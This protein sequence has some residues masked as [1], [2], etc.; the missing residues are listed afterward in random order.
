MRTVIYFA[1]NKADN[2]TDANNYWATELSNSVTKI[3]ECIFRDKLM[4]KHSVDAHQF[5]LSA[6]LFTTTCAHVKKCH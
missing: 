2:L 4:I 3:F 1:K 6:G 5:G